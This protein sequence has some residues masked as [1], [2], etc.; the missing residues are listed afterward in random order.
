MDELDYCGS[1]LDF[2]DIEWLWR[3]LCLSPRRVH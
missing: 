2:A 3:V 1:F